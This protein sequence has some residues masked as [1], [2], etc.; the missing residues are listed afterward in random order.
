MTNTQKR[1][2]KSAVAAVLSMATLI[3]TAY[4]DGLKSQGKSHIPM[5]TGLV[6]IQKQL[7]VPFF[8]EKKTLKTQSQEESVPRLVTQRKE[9][10][11]DRLIKKQ[12]HVQGMTT[13][14][15]E[16][17]IPTFGEVEKIRSIKR[18]TKPA[19]KCGVLHT[20]ERARCLKELSYK[21]TNQYQ[22]F[23]ARSTAT[24]LVAEKR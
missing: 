5:P 6:E 2:T 4:A 23:I 10:L 20:H 1:C 19:N 9:R 14:A 22:N 3:S 17:S 13:K 7:W 8:V 16:K 21:R 12:Q 24:V 11:Q 18:M 15:V